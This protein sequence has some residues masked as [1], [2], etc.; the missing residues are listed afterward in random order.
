MSASLR[1]AAPVARP[2]APV[3]FRRRAPAVI[4]AATTADADS[5]PYQVAARKDL[6]ELRIYGGHYVCRAPYNN[7]E[8]GLA[9][10]HVAKLPHV[11]IG[12]IRRRG[13]TPTAIEESFVNLLMEDN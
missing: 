3:R 12:L 9:V 5:P 11:A 2:R 7:R 4:R 10:V 6:Y 8:K 13:R 1:A